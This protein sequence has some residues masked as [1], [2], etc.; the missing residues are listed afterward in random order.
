[1]KDPDQG[2]KSIFEEGA[3]MGWEAD[4]FPVG[5]FVAYWSIFLL[6]ERLGGME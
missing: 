1:M 4:E 6:K 3:E 5:L 2:S